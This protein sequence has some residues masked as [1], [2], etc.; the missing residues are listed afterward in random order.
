MPRRPRGCYGRRP[1][2]VRL[3]YRSRRADRGLCE[4]ADGR[5]Q[6]DYAFEPIDVTRNG[7]DLIIADGHHRAAAALYTGTPVNVRI[8][9][10]DAF[11]LGPGGWQST[12][13]VI[14]VSHF[15]TPNRL[16]IR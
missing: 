7:D 4:R 15:A 9:G 6:Q 2:D 13:E 11:P 10:P 3:G 16:R 14:S 1:H 8:L 12:N 5:V